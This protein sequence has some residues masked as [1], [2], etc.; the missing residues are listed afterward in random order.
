MKMNKR[1]ISI[2]LSLLLVFMLLP[3][4][5]LAAGR[6]DLD[7]DVS[8]LRIRITERRCPVQFST[9]ILLRQ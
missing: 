6:I 2:C 4:S 1:L 3:V 8:Q 7:Q 9:S 5:A